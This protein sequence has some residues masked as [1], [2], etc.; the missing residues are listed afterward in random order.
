MSVLQLDENTTLE[1][2]ERCI[3]YFSTM[4]PIL[5]A[6]EVKMN[7]SQLVAD[8]ARSLTAAADCLRTDASA[9]LALSKVLLC[10]K[11]VINGN[12]SIQFL[13]TIYLFFFPLYTYTG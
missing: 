13:P 2:L 7:Q 11:K 8:I 3:T 1:G 6:S 10:I 5:L 4:Y 12:C 9:L